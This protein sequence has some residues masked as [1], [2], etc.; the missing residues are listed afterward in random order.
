MNMLIRIEGLL[1]SQLL[2]DHLEV[3]NE[4]HQHNV[5]PGAQTHFKVT[6]VSDKFDQKT[7]V[8]RHRQVYEILREPLASGVHALALHTY[9]T[10]EWQARS[11]GAIDS[12]PCLGGSAKQSG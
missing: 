10:A 3:L 8:A 6:V 4:S 2:P 12:P 9:S 11:G 1:Q 7:L 5:P